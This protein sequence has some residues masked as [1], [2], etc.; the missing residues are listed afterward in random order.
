MGG[1]PCGVSYRGVESNLNKGKRI[2]P[3]GRPLM[4]KTT[5]ALL[6]GTVVPLRLAICLWMVGT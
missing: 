4:G 6:Y 5:Y 2:K 3:I 1:Y